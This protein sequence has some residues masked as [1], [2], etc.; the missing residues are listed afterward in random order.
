MVV[1]QSASVRLQQPYHNMFPLALQ[2]RS[3]V[4]GYSRRTG[5]VDFYRVGMRAPFVEETGHKVGVGE[6]FDVVEPFVIGNQ[7]H[8]LCYTSSTGVFEISAFSDRFTTIGLYKHS[9]TRGPAASTGFTTVKAFATSSQVGVMGYSSEDGRVVIYTVSVV[10]TSPPGTSPLIMSHVW[11]N[12]WAKGWTRFAFFRFGRE[13][14]FL[15]TNTVFPNVNIDHVLDGFAGTAEV[16]SHLH[17]DR[18]S[19]LQDVQPFQLDGDPWFATYRKT[20]ITTLNRIHGDCRGWTTACSFK[21]Q[22]GGDHLVPVPLGS[23]T[24]L[25]V[26]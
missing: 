26:A 3:Y 5:T 11:A 25:L 10:P 9:H 15:K 7:L 20:G 21:S 23:G 13:V 16:G 4:A 2:G 19:Q 24:A 1:R 18:A 17:L 22:R 12:Q 8:L 6:G 14:F